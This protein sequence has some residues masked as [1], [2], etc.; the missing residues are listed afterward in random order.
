MWLSM[1][2]AVTSRFRRATW[3]MWFVPMEK[4]SPSP[5]VM[6]T[7]SSGFAILTPSATAGARPWIVWNP[8]VLKK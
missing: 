2:M 5:P 6:I 3:M 7:R 4:K 8:N 1:Q